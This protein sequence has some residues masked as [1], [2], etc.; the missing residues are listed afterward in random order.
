MRICG[1]KLGWKTFFGLNNSAVITRQQPIPATVF[2]MKSTEADCSP[3][4]DFL[5]ANHWDVPLSSMQLGFSNSQAVPLFHN[6]W[7][8]SNPSTE[9]VNLI[10]RETIFIPAGHEALILGELPGR[11]SPEMFKGIFEPS[12]AFEKYQILTSSSFCESDEMIPTRPINL[13]E[14]ITVPK[15]MSL[16]NLLVVGSPYLA[17][18]NWV[19][20][21]M[22]DYPQS[23]VPDKN[24]VEEIMSEPILTWILRFFHNSGSSIVRFATCSRS[25]NE[26]LAGATLFSSRLTLIRAPNWWDYQIAACPWSTSKDRQPFRTQ[27]DNAML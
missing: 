22:P 2:V 20:A 6:H 8:P 7:G 16:G 18:I 17:A 10:A 19:F 21:D 26:I 14:D 4:L 15:R 9:Q 3:G 23:Q 5:E 11:S 1:R 13:V 12:T 25:H 24:D 27:I